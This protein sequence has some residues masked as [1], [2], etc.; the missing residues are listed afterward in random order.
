[1]LD[2]RFTKYIFL[3][4]AKMIN[5][6]FFDDS[7][8]INPSRNNMKALVGVGGIYVSA[9]NLLILENYL[10]EI[11]N[12]FGFPAGETGEFKW[13]PGKDLWMRKNLVEKERKNFFLKILEEAQKLEV[14]AMVV[15]E[16][17]E[18]ECA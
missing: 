2:E 12:D 4:G 1:M 15:I 13:S 14:S 7:V 5:F 11:C 18:C 10:D 3:G 17:K 9:D 6:F 8:Q 16:E